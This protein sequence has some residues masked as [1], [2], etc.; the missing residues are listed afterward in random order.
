MESPVQ[1]PAAASAP[2]PP[3]LPYVN[4]RESDDDIRADSGVGADDLSEVICEPAG[5]CK[6]A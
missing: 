4:V 3:P 6:T 5:V 2:P 1:R